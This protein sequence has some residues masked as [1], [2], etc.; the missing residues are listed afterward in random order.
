MT[1]RSAASRT[2]PMHGQ[3]DKNLTRSDNRLTIHKTSEIAKRKSFCIEALLSPSTPDTHSK[4]LRRTNEVNRFFYSNFSSKGDYI[5]SNS[6]AD[7][8]DGRS[9]T[10][11]SSQSNGSVTRSE[12]SS[13]PIS[14][15]NENECVIEQD[16]L[17]HHSQNLGRIDS[18]YFPARESNFVVM[19]NNNKPVHSL[20]TYSHTS[21]SSA[22][23]PLA[24]TSLANA[25]PT[26]GT[27][28]ALSA[29]GSSSILANSQHLHHMQLEWLARTGMLY[30]RLPELAG[31]LIIFQ[32]HSS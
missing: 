15:G 32:H 25:V 29:P 21:S 22:F 6:E 11:Y 31:K 2:N 17:M 1:S 18:N 27:K 23:H 7:F 12:I 19:S 8:D 20:L 24:R 14:P 4:D 3:L 13:P 26:V 9:L 5:V 10:P 28:L 16:D 30:P